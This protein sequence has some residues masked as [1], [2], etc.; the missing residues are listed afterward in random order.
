M[1]T[2]PKL[3]I[4]L[5]TLDEEQLIEPWLKHVARLAPFEIIIVDGGSTDRTVEIIK[6]SKTATNVKLIEHPMGDSFSEQRNLAMKKCTGDWVLA[7]DADETLTANAISLLPK[8]MERKNTLAY[9]FPR[10]TLFPDQDH[11]FGHPNGDLQLRLFRN[12][13][14]IAYI[15]KVHERPAYKG[16]EIHPGIIRTEQGWK[17]SRI[18]REIKLLHAGYIKPREK[19]IARGKRWQKFKEASKARGIEVGGEDFFVLDEKKLKIGPIEDLIK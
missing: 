12:L 4:L 1:I 2:K 19:L 7:L 13:P 18:K 9:S 5:I 3:S 17:W 14:Q 10:V 6:S 16:K 8:L 15:H 11:F